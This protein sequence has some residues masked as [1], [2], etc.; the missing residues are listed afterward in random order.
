MDFEELRPI[1]NLPDE[2][3]LVLR[4]VRKA[5]RHAGI[6][7]DLDEAVIEVLVTMYHEL[8]SGQTMDGRSTDRRR[9]K[10]YFETAIAPLRVKSGLRYG[11]LRSLIH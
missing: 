7:V 5:N 1:K 3:G 6:S 8:R 11:P 4:E 10:H 9:L 2:I